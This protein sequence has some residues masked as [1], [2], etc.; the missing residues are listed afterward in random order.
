MSNFIGS[1]SMTASSREKPRV[2][3]TKLGGPERYFVFGVL[4]DMNRSD[5]LLLANL[6]SHRLAPAEDPTR[7][8]IRCSAWRRVHALKCLR[9]WGGSAS[10]RVREGDGRECGEV[11]IPLSPL[12]SPLPSLQPVMHI[13]L[14]LHSHTHLLARFNDW[15][16]GMVHVSLNLFP[17]PALHIYWPRLRLPRWYQRTLRAFLQWRVPVQCSGHRDLPACQHMWC[18]SEPLGRVGVLGGFEPLQ[19]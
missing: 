8:G 16:H 7:M 3:S 6:A 5:I 19:Y 10:M 13:M 9:I 14:L 12:L 2:I 4:K 11:I 15:Q 18:A 1:P 17:L